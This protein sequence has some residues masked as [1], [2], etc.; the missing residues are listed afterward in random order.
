[1]GQSRGIGNIGNKTMNKEKAR[2][3]TDPGVNPCA[4][5]G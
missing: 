1:M 5:E 4:R 2:T 3:K